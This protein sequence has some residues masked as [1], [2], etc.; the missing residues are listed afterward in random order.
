MASGQE[1][2]GWWDLDSAAR[3]GQTVVPGGTGGK[4]FEAQ[5]KLAEGTYISGQL[6]CSDT[7]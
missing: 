4:T 6:I 7:D 1:E 3:A 2:K 5:E